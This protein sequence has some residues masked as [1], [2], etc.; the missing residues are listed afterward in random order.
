MVRLTIVRPVRSGIF[1]APRR[2]NSVHQ[3]IRDSANSL[4]PMTSIAGM[5]V[6]TEAD[7]ARILQFRAAA[8][9]LTVGSW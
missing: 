2:Y 1:R 9:P 3:D 7:I 4:R 5:P 6:L 8:E